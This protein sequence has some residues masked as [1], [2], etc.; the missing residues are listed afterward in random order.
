MFSIFAILVRI[1]FS[2]LY[3]ECGEEPTVSA[4]KLTSWPLMYFIWNI[5][6]CLSVSTMFDTSPSTSS[7][8]AILKNS[9]TALLCTDIGN[10]LLGNR[11]ACRSYLQGGTDSSFGVSVFPSHASSDSNTGH[12]HLVTLTFPELLSLFSVLISISPVNSYCARNS[13]IRFSL[14]SARLLILS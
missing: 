12:T 4:M 13:Y 2:S 7:L 8:R 10:Y 1:L 14:L 11:I 6:Y 3:T 5:M 9:L